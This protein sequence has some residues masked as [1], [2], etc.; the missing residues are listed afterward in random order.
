MIDINPK[1]FRSYKIEQV[2][3]FIAVS[4]NKSDILHGNVSLHYVLIK[5]STQGD[6]KERVKLWLVE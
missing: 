2:P 4:N 1:I 3:A 5:F 6:T